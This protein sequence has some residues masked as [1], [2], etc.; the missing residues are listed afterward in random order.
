L[1]QGRA[2]QLRLHPAS[3]L[4]RAR[5]LCRIDVRTA[6]P[7]DPYRAADLQFEIERDGVLNG[8]AGWFRAELA[9]GVVLETGPDQSETHWLQT[10]FAF[11]PRLVRA[12]TRIEVRASLERDPIH[13][14]NLQVEIGIEGRSIRYRVE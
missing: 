7:S 10:Y 3:L 1:E 14:R 11:P 13:R 2:W 4:G 9:D 6:G 12:G 8:L 5:A